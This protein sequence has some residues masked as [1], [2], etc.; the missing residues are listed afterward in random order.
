MNS[1]V[2]RMV[3]REIRASWRRLLL[4]FLCVALGVSAIVGVRSII[5][6][7]H[8]TLMSE[9]RTLL[10]ADMIIRSRN[11][12]TDDVSVTISKRL[13]EAKVLART[14]SIETATMVRPADATKAI[15]KMIEARG[16]QSGFPFYGVIQIA[17]GQL[18]SHE[19]LAG[20]G[21]LVRP[22]LLTQLD[23]EVGDKILI[24][25][26]AFTIRGV[27]LTEPGNSMGAFSLGSRVLVDHDD[28]QETG[29][30]SFG[31]RANYETLIKISE[32]GIE[33]LVNQ[34]K[35]D[36]SETFIRVRSYHN[37]ENRVSRNLL[38]AE[39][40]LSLIG[41]IIVILGGIGVWSV[42][43][44]FV[45]QKI[46]SIAILKC[47]GATSKDLLTIYLLQVILLA[48]SGS[49]LGVAI[50]AAAIE[51]I[52]S[53]M[54]TGYAPIDYQLTMSA[55]LQ[56]FGIGVLVSLLFSVVPLL[57]VRHV[58]PLLLL[59]YETSNERQ[60]VDWLRVTAVVVVIVAL[61]GVASW[62]AGSLTIGFYVSGGFALLAICLHFASS[63]LIKAVAPLGRLSWFPLRHAVMS[64]ASPG[65]QTRTII[66]AV[67]LGSF[68]LIGIRTLQTNL[69]E[70]FALEIRDDAPDMYLI[71]IQY[72]QADG[73]RDFLSD[74]GDNDSVELVPVLRARVTGVAGKQVNLE[75]VEDVRGMGS[76][77]RE[78]VV[79]YRATFEKNEALVAGRVWSDDVIPEVSIEES[80]RDRFQI[81]VGD[82]MDFAV[83]GRTV[84]ATVS[85]V[86]T[87]EWSDTR[88]GGFMFVF[89]PDTFNEAPHSYMATM[90]GPVSTEQRAKM[91]RNLVEMYPNVSIIDVREIMIVAKK[92][93]DTVTLAVSTVGAISV[94]IGVLILC[95]AV[96]M[97]KFQRL[98]D[99]SIF[100]MLGANSKVITTMLLIEY[101]GLGALAGLI[102]SC[103]AVILTWTLSR[104]VFE[105]GWRF[106]YVENIGG[107][108]ATA[109]LVGAVGVL[110][111]L[112]VLY[113]KPMLILRTE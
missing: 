11:P 69:L 59:R 39:N 13:E 27:M 90:R 1:F 81:D 53:D 45:R 43:R 84:R 80:I 34:L 102:G 15:A 95:G 89:R 42:T 33:P 105:I 82:L 35:E 94:L 78:Y 9:A 37:S 46:K 56:G 66:L 25:D 50:A 64:L 85:S 55:T 36:L 96:A 23:V 4:F 28:L 77:A 5:Q 99:S 29:L 83:L 98:Y 75:G 10:A 88:R 73:V 67:G 60:L 112:D 108:L 2:L 21:A 107:I 52:P 19:L 103:G 49:L 74:H 101:L 20:Q 91:Q 110:S 54:V 71:D 92:M 76:L 32:E 16:V 24:G 3:S 68:F 8:G 87:V 70:E 79:T 22:E 100:R 97:T 38:R 18:Y 41:F 57:D 58:R 65:N 47:I 7:T 104:F 14:E 31:S 111:S 61:I 26:S 86:R 48:V 44:V 6:S 12:W 109:F 17:G 40:Y 72:D 51:A 106:T 93:L 62:Q 113:R 63:V 30:L